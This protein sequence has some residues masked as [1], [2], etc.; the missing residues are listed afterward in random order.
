MSAVEEQLPKFG[1][2]GLLKPRWFEM[3]PWV[4]VGKSCVPPFQ[5]LPNERRVAHLKAVRPTVTGLFN[6][7]PRP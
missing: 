6:L 1:L 4:R 7:V 2:P 3:F 5:L